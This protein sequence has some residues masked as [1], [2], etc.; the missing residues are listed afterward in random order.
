MTGFV[1][2]AAPPAEPVT[3]AE[4]YVHLRTDTSAGQDDLIQA[5]IKAAR[6]WCENYCRRSFVQR[7]LQ[8]RMDTFPPGQIK[9]PRGPVQSIT[10]VKVNGTAVSTSVYEAD[11]Y[12]QPPRI[13]PVYGATWPIPTPAMNAVVVEY[14]V[15]YAPGAASPTDYAE[16]IP[17][18]IKAAIKLIVGHLYE[19]RETVVLGNI[20]VLTVPFTVKALLA[21]YEIRDFTLE[22]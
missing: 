15:G 7:S 11:L 19:N 13:A 1:E 3:L 10:S 14:V 5:L 2:V 8:L 17:S 18:S 21:P 9:L 12:G 16:N 20:Q 22:Q 6:E 4:L